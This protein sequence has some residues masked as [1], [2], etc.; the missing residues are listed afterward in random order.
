MFTWLTPLQHPNLRLRYNSKIKN[1][2]E[3]MSHLLYLNSRDDYPNKCPHI[4]LHLLVKQH[5]LPPRAQITAGA[6]PTEDAHYTHRPCPC[7]AF[8]ENNSGF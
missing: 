3:L 5:L 8:C 6:T 7:K 2:N 4:C 1:Y